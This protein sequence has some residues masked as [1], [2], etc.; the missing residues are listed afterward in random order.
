MDV[1]SLLMESFRILQSDRNF[2]GTCREGLV[3]LIAAPTS[4][5]LR[6]AYL[7]YAL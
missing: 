7:S 3:D 4:W 2:G 6:Y 1:T 5:L